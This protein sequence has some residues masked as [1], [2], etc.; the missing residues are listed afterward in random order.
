MSDKVAATK[1]KT[2]LKHR[3]VAKDHF[4]S[5]KSQN[6]PNFS[7][8]VITFIEGKSLLASDVETGKSDPVCFVWC[9]P[10][11]E[12][13]DLNTTDDE[14]SGI[15]KTKVCPTTTDPIWNEDV[16]F[17][18]DFNDINVLSSLKCLIY[19]RDE[20]I[21]EN[22]EYS[23]DELGMLEIFFKDIISKGKSLKTGIVLSAAWYTLKKSPGMR[24]VDGKIKLT[25][26]LVI[27]QNDLV[28]LST[29]LGVE[30][31]E[32]MAQT[33]LIKAFQNVY[34]ST[35]SMD[36]RAESP[37]PN[38]R[39]SVGELFLVTFLRVDDNVSF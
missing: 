3:D 17:P 25:I 13:P 30:N 4:S 20:D 19:V 32:G 24:K 11:D 35:D 23:Y 36:S 39:A 28:S 14:N 37:G 12:T 15:L 10:A 6:V 26:N 18:L 21:S 38:L 22:N 31:R 34:K 5:G 8:L 29:Q 16:V 7:R 33:G 1:V 9:G 27:H 2:G